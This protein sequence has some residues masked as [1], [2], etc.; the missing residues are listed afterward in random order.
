MTKEGRTLGGV[1]PGEL[2]HCPSG[3]QGTMSEERLGLKDYAPLETPRPFISYIWRR[4]QRPIGPGVS[5]FAEAS[6]FRSG[7]GDGWPAGSTPNERSG[8]YR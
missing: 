2:F 7:A 1:E 3:R 5:L 6:R 4:K 8:R